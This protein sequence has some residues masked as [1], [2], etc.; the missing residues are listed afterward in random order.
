MLYETFWEEGEGSGIL[1]WPRVSPSWSL[2]LG[3][4]LLFIFMR[5]AFL[6]K[7]IFVSFTA[8]CPAGKDGNQLLIRASAFC[9]YSH[10]SNC[11]VLFP[12]SSLRMMNI[13]MLGSGVEEANVAAHGANSGRW[14]K[15][16]L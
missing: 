15:S 9:L 12:C 7:F 6:D 10:C 4:S 8:S 1:A 16:F 2:F 5:N 13:A 14:Q 3:F 11:S